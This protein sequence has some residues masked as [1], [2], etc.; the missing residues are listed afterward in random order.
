MLFINK[1]KELHYQIEIE[2]LRNQLTKI[3]KLYNEL[4]EENKKL[5]QGKKKYKRIEKLL[6]VYEKLI[7]FAPDDEKAVNNY[8]RLYKL[9]ENK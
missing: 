9:K 5:K 1:D 6:K 2:A 3:E 4:L 8:I 7:C